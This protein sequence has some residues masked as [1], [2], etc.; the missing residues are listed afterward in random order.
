[1][2]ASQVNDFVKQ[3]IA[4]LTGKAS[5]KGLGSGGTGDISSNPL[6]AMQREVGGVY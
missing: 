2:L 1:M 6:L 4:P 5:D 3:D